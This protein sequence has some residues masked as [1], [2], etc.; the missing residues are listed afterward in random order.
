MALGTLLP[1][2]VA[3]A[4]DYTPSSAIKLVKVDRCRA[5][6]QHGA[7]CALQDAEARAHAR[8]LARELAAAQGAAAELRRALAAQGAERRGAER[9]VKDAEVRLAAALAA[10]QRDGARADARIQARAP[11]M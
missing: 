7:A 2:I 6:K 8:E 4:S 3:I 9:R 10:R 11:A 1:V 5:H